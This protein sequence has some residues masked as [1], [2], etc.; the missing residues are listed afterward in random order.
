MR[1]LKIV[2]SGNWGRPLEQFRWFSKVLDDKDSKDDTVHMAVDWRSQ[3]TC[4]QVMLSFFLMEWPLILYLLLATLHRLREGLA[5]L[6][7]LAAITWSQHCAL[8]G[9]VRHFFHLA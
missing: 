4:S 3:R 7:G 5:K 9:G 1:I 2:G 6:R 8:S